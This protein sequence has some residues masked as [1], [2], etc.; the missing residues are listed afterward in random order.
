[1]DAIRL[2]GGAVAFL[3]TERWRPIVYYSSSLPAAPAHVRWLRGRGGGGR[4]GGPGGL[5]RLLLREYLQESF[6]APG[7]HG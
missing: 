2:S 6:G 4:P 3:G 1:M 5:L 7:G